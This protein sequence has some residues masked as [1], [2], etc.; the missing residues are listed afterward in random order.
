[1]KHRLVLTVVA[2]EGNVLT[3]IHIL[4]VIG[5]KTAITTL[6]AFAKYL[7]DFLACLHYLDRRANLFHDAAFRCFNKLDEHIDLITARNVFADLFNG[8][9]GVEFRR[10]QQVEC[11]VE[12]RDRL[13]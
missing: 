4:E 10:Q 12:A 2:K 7:D 11:V 6:N 9:R 3:Q 5:D 8:L 1:M 13:F